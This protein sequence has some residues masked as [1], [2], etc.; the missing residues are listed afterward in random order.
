MSERCGICERH[1]DESGE[2]LD[3][4]CRSCN[5]ESHEWADEEEAQQLE[6]E[7]WEG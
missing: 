2:L 1:T 4:V 6:E 3:D 7:L 5:P